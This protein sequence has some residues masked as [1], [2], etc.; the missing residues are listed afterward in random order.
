MCPEN[1]G[2][3]L[4]DPDRLATESAVHSRA[5]GFDDDD[6]T[7]VI[8]QAL[9]VMAARSRRH[10][11]DLGAALRGADIAVDPVRLRAALRRLCA[12]GAIDHLVPLSDGRLL[13]TV[14][15]RRPEHPGW[16]SEWRLLDRLDTVAD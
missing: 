5:D 7:V 9:T 8:L 16:E 3:G 10:Q 1:P 15:Q 12:R 4:S 6:L 13:L 14:T 2:P 11:A